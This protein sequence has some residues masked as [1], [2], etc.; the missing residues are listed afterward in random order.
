LKCLSPTIL[1]RNSFNKTNLKSNFYKKSDTEKEM[2]SKREVE[3]S[4]TNDFGEK[5]IQ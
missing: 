2:N 5:F 3:M 4:V 1:V